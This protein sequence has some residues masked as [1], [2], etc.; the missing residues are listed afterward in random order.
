MPTQSCSRCVRPRHRDRLAY[1]APRCDRV[2]VTALSGLCNVCRLL[3]R[4]DVDAASAKVSCE[5]VQSSLSASNRVRSLF[6]ASVDRDQPVSG[7][8]VRLCFSALSAAIRGHLQ[9]CLLDSAL[10]LAKGAPRGLQ[11]RWA[12]FACEPGLHAVVFL[13]SMAHPCGCMLAVTEHT[14]RDMMDRAHPMVTIPWVQ[15]RSSTTCYTG[16]PRQVSSSPALSRPRYVQTPVGWPVPF[17]PSIL[18]VGRFHAMSMHLVF[19]LLW[20]CPEA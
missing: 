11:K 1:R 10:M 19:H 5:K 4:A 14:S 6:V 12:T 18:A 15:T 3:R 7:P 8:P 2:V 9:G 17:R 16:C 20:Q 13:C